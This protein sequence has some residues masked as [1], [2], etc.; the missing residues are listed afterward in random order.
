MAAS[1]RSTGLHDC[2]RDT[3]AP[4]RAREAILSFAIHLLP[5]VALLMKARR[6]ASLHLESGL[7]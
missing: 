6:M 2:T 7:V 1:I 5:C 3:M 4:I